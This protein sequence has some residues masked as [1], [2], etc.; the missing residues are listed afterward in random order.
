MR[1]ELSSTFRAVLSHGKGNS[2]EG[3]EQRSEL[4]GDNTLMLGSPRSESLLAELFL[5]F[6]H[7]TILCQAAGFP[8]TSPDREDIVCIRAL[9]TPYPS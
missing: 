1:T 7:Q 4:D 9:V 6:M 5:F 3:G 8:G 2:A